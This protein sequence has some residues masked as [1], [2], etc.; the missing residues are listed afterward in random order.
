VALGLGGQSATAVLD[1]V[2]GGGTPVI[3][4]LTIHVASV[5]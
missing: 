3:N 1:E 4:D 5:N 2:S